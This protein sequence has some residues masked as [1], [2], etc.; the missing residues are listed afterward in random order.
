[1]C[2]SVVK[3]SVLLLSEPLRFSIHYVGAVSVKDELF[4]LPPQR[5]RYSY[6]L[7]LVLPLVR[8]WNRQNPHCEN[9]TL[10]LQL[11]LLHLISTIIMLLFAR[12]SIQT[13]SRLSVR[14][15]DEEAK[16]VDR[17]VERR[18]SREG[19]RTCGGR[20]DSVSL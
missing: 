4:F 5:S 3:L 16:G 11:L 7:L 1:M 14:L 9:I 12:C 18:R 10:F 20:T 2:V 6:K 8:L 17:V 13:H 19:R 15:S